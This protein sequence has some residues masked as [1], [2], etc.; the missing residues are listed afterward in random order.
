MPGHNAEMLALRTAKAWGYK[1]HEWRAQSPDDRMQMMGL[2][3][4]EGTVEAYRAEWREDKR[5]GRNE[6]EGAN[7]YDRL[8][9]RM[10]L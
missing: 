6:G 10:K 2:D 8:K 1:L 4:F 3:M 9:K 5:K 7:D